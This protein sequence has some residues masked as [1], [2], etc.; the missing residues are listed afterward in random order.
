MKL[1]SL[2][3]DHAVLQRHQPIPVWGWTKPGVRVRVS[4]AGVVAETMAD[5]HGA[6]MLRLPALPAGGPHVLAVT[7][8]DKAESCIV[9]DILIGEVW[10]CSGQSNMQWSMAISQPDPDPKDFPT[11]RMFN[12]QNSIVAERAPEPIGSWKVATQA[13]VADFSAVGYFFARSLT[14]ALKVPVG[15]VNTA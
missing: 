4:L 5:A 15:M 9:S 2:F 1:H 6:F 3:S 7:S 8:N 13:N 12:A 14:E 10:V 11:L